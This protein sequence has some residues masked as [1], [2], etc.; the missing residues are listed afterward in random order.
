MVGRRPRAINWAAENHKSWPAIPR[1]R[2]SQ[3]RGYRDDDEEAS[4][5]REESPESRHTDRSRITRDTGFKDEAALLAAERRRND[6]KRRVLDGMRGF[7][8]GEMGKKCRRSDAELRKIKSNKIRTFY[9][10]QNDTLDAW[11]EVDALVYAVADDVIDSMNPDAD[12]DGIPE[13]RMPLKDS[14][15]AIDCFLP[16]EHR[17][18]RAREE[19]HARRAIN[20]NLLANIFMLAAKLVSLK[21]SPSLSLAASTADS[22]LDLFCTLIVY[23]TNR[24]VAWRLEALQM[25][26]PVGRRRLE[27]IGILVF[28]VI[29]VVS[30]V[31]ILQESVTKLLPGGSREVAPLP[32]VAI[33][34]MASNAVIK[35]LIGFACR[36]VKTTQVQALVQDCKTD[37]YFNIASLL[38][39]L[40]GV[41][42]DI[43]WLDPVGAS[44]LAVYVI[45]DWAETCMRNVSRLTGSN[46][47]NA[48]QKK[49]MY[50]AFRFAPVVEGF[51]SLTAYH[52]GDGVWVEL[53][54]L[55]DEKTPLPTAHDIAETLQYC[56]EGLQ[57]VDRAFV[58][59]DYSTLGPTGHAAT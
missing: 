4:L 7:D 52:A 11:L 5:P 30:F 39:P 48:L 36:H 24:L 2:P 31:Q 56:Y 28:S 33:A 13:R 41:H 59:V 57:E 42:A 23:G 26:Y 38:F 49:L 12:G 25:K 53:D 46:V 16:A 47:G 1:R 15:G 17:E 51:K 50:L 10:A 29:M 19:K 58:T 32:A 37:V 35:G 8:L 40:V 9:E 55:L 34:A 22:A 27:P 54:I 20:I 14:R 43:W 45:I 3:A 6:L 18:K 44:L 21:F